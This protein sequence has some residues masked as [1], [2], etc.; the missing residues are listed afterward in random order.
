VLGENTMD[1]QQ[2]LETATLLPTQKLHL[3]GIT[4]VFMLPYGFSP[5]AF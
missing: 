5:A 1:T 2:T 3:L 4:P